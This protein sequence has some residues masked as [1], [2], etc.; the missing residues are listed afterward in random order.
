MELDIDYSDYDNVSDEIKEQGRTLDNQ[1]DI[2][3]NRIK[4]QLNLLR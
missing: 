1:Q 2:A 4:S 3:L